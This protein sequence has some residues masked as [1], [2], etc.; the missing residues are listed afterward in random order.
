MFAG[1][2]FPPWLWVKLFLF[3]QVR[4]DLSSPSFSSTTIQNFQDISDLLSE[5][6][7][8]QHHTKLCSKCRL[9]LVFFSQIYIPF[10]GEMKFRLYCGLFILSSLFIS[11]HTLSQL[12]PI[13]MPLHIFP[14]LLSLQPFFQWVCS[15]SGKLRHRIPHED[16]YFTWKSDE[17]LKSSEFFY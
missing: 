1:Y 13:N 15:E 11:R 12:N 5:V 8:F 6:F 7:K 14:I 2:T 16:T 10:A 4:P 3:S 9:L 17:T